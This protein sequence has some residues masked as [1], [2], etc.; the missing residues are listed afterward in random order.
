MNKM[1]LYFMKLIFSKNVVD[2]MSFNKS[3]D[4]KN[5]YR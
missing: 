4:Q 5:E 2:F 3:I 1:I